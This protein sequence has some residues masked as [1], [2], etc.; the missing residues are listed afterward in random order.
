PIFKQA[1]PLRILENAARWMA[2]EK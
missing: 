1:E 2:T